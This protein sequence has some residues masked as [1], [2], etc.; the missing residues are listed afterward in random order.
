MLVLLGSL[1]AVYLGL[2][3]GRTQV[4]AT[5]RW[6]VRVA[7]SIYLGWITVATVA[8]ATSLLYELGW[9]GW[10][11]SPEAWAAIMLVVAAGLAV[12]MSVRH[13]DVAYVAVIVWALIGIAV[14]HAGTPAVSGVAWAMAAVAALSLAVGVPR[15]RKRLGS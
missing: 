7:F 3:T 1:I 11:I 13:G 6:A 4:P 5:E 10:G 15:V 12:A 8:N 14:K 2:E 9:G